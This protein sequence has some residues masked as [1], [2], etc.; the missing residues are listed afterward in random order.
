MRRLSCS[1]YSSSLHNCWYRKRRVET[2][3]TRT[4]RT[5]IRIT[6]PVGGMWYYR[7]TLFSIGSATLTTAT[8]LRDDQRVSFHGPVSLAC[9]E[10]QTQEK[11][12]RRSSFPCVRLC[13]FQRFVGSTLDSPSQTECAVRRSSRFPMDQ[14]LRIYSQERSM[15][16]TKEVTS[17]ALP[18]QSPEAHTHMSSNTVCRWFST[19]KTS[20]QLPRWNK[21]SSSK[22]RR[23]RTMNCHDAPSAEEPVVLWHEI[24][25]SPKCYS[26]VA[27]VL[28]ESLLRTIQRCR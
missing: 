9:E 18:M 7:K 1:V 12:K 6:N 15:D 24:P 26:K 11:K 19:T 27:K 2:T 17:A 23:R 13:A 16:K 28:A 8:S 21:P 4:T 14:C 5:R 3:K 10:T 22:K 20:Q 25:K